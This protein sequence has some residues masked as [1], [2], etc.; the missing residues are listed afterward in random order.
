MQD[1][2]KRTHLPTLVPCPVERKVFSDPAVHL[3][4]CHLSPDR[5]KKFLFL[6]QISN[7]LTL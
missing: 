1:I 4:Q 3:V 7:N 5:G 2:C 6:Q